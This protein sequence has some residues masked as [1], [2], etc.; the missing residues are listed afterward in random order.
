MSTENIQNNSVKS[1]YDLKL[2]KDS[3]ISILSARRTGKSFLISNL[4]HYFLTNEK[5][6]VDYVYLFSNTAGLNSNTNE[7]YNFLDKK[8]IVPAKPEI[9]Q[10]VITGL[11]QTQKKTGF[12]FS[13]LI[14]FDDIVLTHKYEI[15]ETLA[16]MGRHFHIT[17][18]LSAQIANT[19]VSPT[20]RNNTSYIF[21]RRIGSKSLKDNIFPTLNVAF[22]DTKE[23][24]RYTKE[25]TQD[26]QFIFYNNNKDFARIQY[27]L[28]EQLIFQKISNILFISPMKS[29]R[30]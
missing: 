26:F 19:C 24:L 16:S 7:Q 18:L 21:W 22:D 3:F 12:K 30:E 9:M 15:I 14:V 20:I 1:I 28:L 5:N 27:K 17:T 6:K 2:E 11:M 10:Q 29:Q 8:C 4:I 13:L 25:N 23:L